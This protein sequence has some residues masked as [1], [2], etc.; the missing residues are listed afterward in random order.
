MKLEDRPI[1]GEPVFA[2][3]YGIGDQ[4]ETWEPSEGNTVAL[5][6]GEVTILAKITKAE[7]RVYEGEVMGFENYDEYEF[8]SKKPGDIIQ[9]NYGHIIGCSK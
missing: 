7:E 3:I 4:I 6:S 5:K 1:I 8:E 2:G 9:F